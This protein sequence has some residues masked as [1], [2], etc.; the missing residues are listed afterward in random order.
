MNKQ[1]LDFSFYE[2]NCPAFENEKQI[3][4]MKDPQQQ[5]NNRSTNEVQLTRGIRPLTCN[6]RAFGKELKN[7]NNNANKQITSQPEKLQK[8]FVKISLEK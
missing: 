8:E 6:S 4:V 1:N 5:N 3:Q 2:S 7:I